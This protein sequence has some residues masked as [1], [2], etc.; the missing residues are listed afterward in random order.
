MATLCDTV[1]TQEYNAGIIN[2]IQLLMFFDVGKTYGTA[3]LKKKQ[4]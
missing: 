4:Q 2:D 3:T 1:L